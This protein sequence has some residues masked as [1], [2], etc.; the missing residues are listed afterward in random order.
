MQEKFLFFKKIKI[1]KG[2]LIMAGKNS[3]ATYVLE[4]LKKR[5]INNE[6]KDG[7][8]LPDQN[9]LAKE[10]GVSRIS[11]R[12]AIH[13]LTLTGALEK[14]PGF[15]T[16]IRSVLQILHIDYLF[17]PKL[18]DNSNFSELM[19]F[20]QYI[21]SAAVELAAIYA[22]QKN[23]SVLEELLNEMKQHL[24]NHKWEEC[25]MADNLFHVEVGRASQNRFILWQV[26]N[27]RCHN[28]QIMHQTLP[29][30]ENIMKDSFEY[31]GN[32]LLAIKNRDPAAAKNQMKAHLAMVSKVF[33]NQLFSTLSKSN[34]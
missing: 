4:E 31:H 5:C 7:D 2:Q 13:T 21:E 33:Q 12:E 34:P 17:P 15:G 10:L 14:R 8:K 30:L 25:A 24:I 3:T 6:L 19:V 16:V 9:Q 26:V 23:I 1:A 18:S 11:L 20:R 29:S 27:S 28:D 22:T 32:I